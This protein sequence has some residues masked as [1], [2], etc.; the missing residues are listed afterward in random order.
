MSIKYWINRKYLT[1]ITIE[2][3]RPAIKSDATM[4]GKDLK[5]E[6]PLDASVYYHESGELFAEDIDQHMTVLP[7]VV[8]SPGGRSR[9]TID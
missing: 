4:I 7:E 5:D 9:C 6:C 1:V 8:T 3:N 2:E